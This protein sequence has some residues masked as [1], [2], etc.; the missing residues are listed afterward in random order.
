[1]TIILD[2]TTG[3]TTPGLINTGTE[4]VVNLTTS[5]NTTL[6]D[7]S[8]DTLT[9]NGSTVSTPNG[10]N[11]DSNTF[12]ID[13]SNNRV[14]I[15]TASPS[16][17]LTVA[18]EVRSTTTAGFVIN[19]GS[20]LGSLKY[21]GGL[22]IDRVAGSTL[23]ISAGGN[24]QAVIDSSGNVGIGTSSPSNKL[25][26]VGSAARIS[27]AGT[28]NFATRNSTA[29]VN[30]E[31]GVD[32]GGNGFVY[33]GQSSA[34]VFSNSATERMRIDSSGR[35]L[36]GATS[37]DARM[38]VTSSS[39]N[40]NTGTLYVRNT[41]ATADACIA[42]FSTATNSTSTSN[43]YIKFGVNDYAGGGGQIN[44]NGS[45]AAAFGSFSDR[46]LKE[47]IVEL[48]SQL[49]NILSLKPVEFDYIESAGGGHQTGFIAQEMQE[50]YPDAVGERSDGMLTLTGW[51]KT[52]ARLVK[53]IQEQQVIINDLKARIET[54]ES[55]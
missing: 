1:M 9:L 3:I 21:S 23:F 7:A 29:G 32:G 11:F 50:I 19:N 26:I 53:A 12:V 17:A 45:G 24:N 33:T 43:V 34:M 28:A 37:G 18:G 10:L 44:A 38:V 13:A 20:E 48:P 49:N 14:G 41:N 4:T 16:V 55:K 36:V 51:D 15:G 31:W 52:T 40:N 47:N 6:G 39:E 22:V 8:G 35:V 54:L 2:G 27:N 25:D 5:G 30:W 46:R 42:A